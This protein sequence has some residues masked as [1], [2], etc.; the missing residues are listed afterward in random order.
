[1]LPYTFNTWNIPICRTTIHK[2]SFYLLRKKV[3]TTNNKIY[4]SIYALEIYYEKFY[5][6]CH[7]F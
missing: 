6:S 5:T 1:M 3:Y 4:F 2:Y 7:C